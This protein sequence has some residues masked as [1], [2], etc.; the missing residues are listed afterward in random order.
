VIDP[1]AHPPFIALEV[2]NPV[3]DRFAPAGFRHD[4]VM[5]THRLGLAGRPPRLAGILEGADQFLLLRVNGD[6]RLLVRLGAR[7][8]GGDVAKL[9][10]AIRMLAAFRGLDVA[11]RL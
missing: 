3:G 2:V 8:G 10:I 11:W 4:K 9:R 5:N 6:R 7:D 1:D